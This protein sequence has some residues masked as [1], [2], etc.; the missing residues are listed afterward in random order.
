ME[1]LKSEEI[2]R[3]LAKGSSIT[4]KIGMAEL[5]KTQPTFPVNYL[6]NWLLNYSKS[7]VNRETLHQVLRNKEVLMYLNPFIG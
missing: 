1:Y 6:A 3:V 5:Y 4:H 7:Q 2:G